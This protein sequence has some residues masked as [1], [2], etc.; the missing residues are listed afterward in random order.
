MLARSPVVIRLIAA[1]LWLKAAV[2]VVCVFAV[3]L[4]PSARPTA[5]SIIEGLVPMIMAW[6]EPAQDIWLAPIFAFVDVVL[7]IGIWFL[8]KWARTVVVVDLVWLYGRALLGLPAALAY[9]S[10]AHLRNPSAYFDLNIVAGL[11]IL[12][13]LCDPGVKRAFGIRF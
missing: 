7:G 11:L 6:R 1:Y 3:Y 12:A 10:K 8:Q 13:A 9:G 2:L 4:R 5:N